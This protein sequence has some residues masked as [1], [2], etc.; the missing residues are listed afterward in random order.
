MKTGLEILVEKYDEEIALKQNNVNKIVRELIPEIEEKYEI[1][2]MTG[3]KTLM[4]CGEVIEIEEFETFLN[5][6]KKIEEGAKP[7]DCKDVVINPNIY[8]EYEEFQIA[9]IDW[10]FSFTMFVELRNHFASLI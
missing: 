3:N 4:V 1:A 8:F 7:E 6:L 2:G 5:L 9:Y 10:L